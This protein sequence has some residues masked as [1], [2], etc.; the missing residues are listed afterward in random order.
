MFPKSFRASSQSQFMTLSM[1]GLEASG[2]PHPTFKP[3]NLH[4]TRTIIYRETPCQLR[5]KQRSR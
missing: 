5:Q 1:L 3:T 2:E 4:N